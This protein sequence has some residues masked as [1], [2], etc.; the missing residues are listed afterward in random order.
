MKAERKPKLTLIQPGSRTDLFLSRQLSSSLF[1]YGTIFTMLLPLILDQFFVS[2][3]NILTTAMISAS[4]QESVSAVSL[5]SPLYMMIF[6][7]FNA[8]SAGGTVVVAQFKGRGN[9]EKIRS[10]SGQVVL[11]SFVLSLIAS[12]TLILF[13]KQLIGFMFGAADPVI[14]VKAEDYLVGIAISLIFLSI[15]MGGFAVF[16]GIGET[17]ICLHLTMIIN[18]IHLFASVLFL[19]VL[20]LDIIGTV[21]SLNIARIIG[22]VVSMALLLRRRQGFCISVRDIFRIDWPILKSVLKIGL[23]FGME[24]VFYNGGSMLVQTYVVMLGTISVAANAICNSAF[25]LLYT[26]GLAVSTLAVTV[27]GQCIGAQEKQLAKHYGGKMIWLGNAITVLSLIILLPLL[28]LL[29]KMYQAPPDTLHLI[30]RLIFIAALPMPFF[31]SMANVMPSVLRSAGDSMFGSIISLITMW[32]IRVGLGYVLAI[33]LGLGV[34]GVWICL[35]VEWA[36]RTLIFY[37]RFR[38]GIWLQKHTI[39]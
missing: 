6:A 36:V 30:Y 28:P 4:S 19:N 21:L 2:F 18:L 12:I 24:Q 20:K 8:I 37:L 15:Y 23:P 26:A 27:V 13:S 14:L 17:K 32:I 11:S 10:A 35:G 25:S 33:P 39:D 34:Q 29:L 7:V 38:S 3:I 16:R 22:A 5:V 1:T 31:W 9:P